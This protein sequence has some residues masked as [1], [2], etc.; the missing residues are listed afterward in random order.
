MSNWKEN[1]VHALI[2]AALAVIIVIVAPL[3]GSVAW[4]L[5]I[6]MFVVS[7]L[8]STFLWNRKKKI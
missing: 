1:L 3:H 4:W 5:P 2:M 6:T 7:F 8:S